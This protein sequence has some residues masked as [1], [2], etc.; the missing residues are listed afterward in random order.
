MR[1]LGGSFAALL[2]LFL[3]VSGASLATPGKTRA[4]RG[5]APRSSTGRAVVLG[6]HAI[7]SLPDDPVLG[8]YCV[9]PERFAAQ[10]DRLAR[11]G[12]NFVDLDAVLAALRGERTLPRRAVLVTFD[13][14]YEDLLQVAAPILEAR[15]IP[16]VAFAVAGQLGG[17]NEWDCE[18]GATELR[19]LD[20]AGLK[21][22]AARGVEVGGH[23]VTHPS[24]PEVSA[25]RLRDELAGCAE[26]LE[27]AGLPRPRAF[28]YPF[29]RWNDG[30]AAAVREAGYEV[31]F[32]T[33][34]GLVRSGVDPHAL[35][36]LAVHDD[37]SASKLFLK[38]ATAPLRWKLRSALGRLRG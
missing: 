19:L 22:L 30:V 15:G 3:L 4:A 35:P 5:T 18:K 16:A 38:V 33:D 28:A 26:R 27:A 9:A 23:T 20:A 36:R 29:G 10:L 1:R 17:R 13:D 6:Y 7:A 14:A 2:A 37:D 31:A 24:L 34:W 11:T 25:D 12:W 8:R 21:E 32:T